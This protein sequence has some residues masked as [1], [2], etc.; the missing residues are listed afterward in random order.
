MKSPLTSQPLRTPGQSVGEQL[1]DRA[2]NIFPWVVL[3]MFFVLMAGLEWYRYFYPRD[4]TPWGVS[5]LAVI[6]VIIA[7]PKLYR[8]RTILRRYRQGRD[9]EIAVGQHLDS[10]RRDGAIT[11]HDIPGKD[12]NLDHVVVCRQGLFVIETKTWSKPDKG[13][14]VIGFDGQTL[15]KNGIDIGNEPVIQARAAA[16]FLS[17]L[18]TE[19]TGRTITAQPVIAF[20][21]WFVENSDGF[22]PGSVWALS[23]RSLPKFINKLPER[24]S[25]EEVH[26]AA[27]HLARFVRSAGKTGTK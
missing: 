12:F 4:P 6:A 15:V 25:D 5:A 23:A 11:L 8:E 7:A 19:S 1:I 10:M 18:L 3:P 14:S 16:D 9:G 22:K 17:Q 26:Q 13:E 2:D 27:F 24:L 21:G 20:P